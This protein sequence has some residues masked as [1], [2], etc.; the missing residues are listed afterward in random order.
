MNSATSRW[1]VKLGR[2][3]RKFIQRQSKDVQRRL[4]RAISRLEETPY[5]AGCKKLSGHP[6]L[7]RLREGNWRII[8][9]V[10]GDQLVILIVKIA[11]RGEV[12]RNL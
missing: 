9:F 5:P 12:Y 3:A 4:E 11:S 1:K 10:E 7:Y 2:K 6:N 8:Y